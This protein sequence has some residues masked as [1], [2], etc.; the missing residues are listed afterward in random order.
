MSNPQKP[1]RK[2]W[3]DPVLSLVIGNGISAAILASIT[4]IGSVA[5]IFIPNVRA[6]LAA[7]FVPNWAA[8]LSAAIVIA[9]VIA[10]R[11]KPGVKIKLIDVDNHLGDTE[12]F[13]LKV[14]CEMARQQHPCE[15]VL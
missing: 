4:A 11:S 1:L 13:R 14:Y 5:A 15:K 3:H 2:I 12:T 10:R 8:L 7:S 6:F 9:I